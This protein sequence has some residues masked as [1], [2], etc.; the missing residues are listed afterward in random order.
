M[1]VSILTPNSSQRLK[2]LRK[3][4][5]DRFESLPWPTQIDEQW[6]RTDP[7]PFLL[8]DENQIS[9]SA[10]SFSVKWEPVAPELIKTGVILTDLTTAMK[11]FPELMDEYLFQTGAPEQLAKFVALH[12]TY[13]NQGLFC[14]VP[15]G[16]TVDLPLKAGIEISGRGGVVFPHILLVAGEGSSVTL[17]DE[18]TSDETMADPV[19]SNEMVEI[20]VKKGATARYIH[21][22]RWGSA[23]AELFTQ[24]AVLEQDAQFLNIHVGLGGK[25]T[26]ANVETTL[27]GPGARADLL[28]VFSGR[29]AQH[30]DFHTLQDHVAERT[31]SDLLYKS[32]LKDTSES[33]YTGLIRI[34]KKAQKSDAYQANRNLL[35]SKGAKADSVPMLEIEANDVRCTHGV[36]VGPVDEEQAFYLM[37]R[38]IPPAEAEHLIVEGF[39]LEVLKRLPTEI[40]RE[41]LMTE[42]IHNLE[43]SDPK[44]SDPRGS[45]PNV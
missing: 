16:V 4:G 19:V 26:K 25:V 3:S 13:W 5:W 27:T 24:R 36:A 11:Q 28:G 30:F 8:T 6:R 37:S 20:I 21:L 45:D 18:R 2:D 1:T 17:I 33:I 10:A 14:C 43:G 40:L 9:S 35:L 31:T 22:Q 32:A 39:F 38:G 29:D 44:G 41:Q 15:E 7:T 12:Q 23:V 42:I 34:E